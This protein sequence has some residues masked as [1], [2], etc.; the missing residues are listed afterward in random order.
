MRRCR[1]TNLLP[2]ATVKSATPSPASVTVSAGLLQIWHPQDP[3]GFECT[4]SRWNMNITPTHVRQPMAWLSP[5]CLSLLP[6]NVIH[7]NATLPSFIWSSLTITCV[8]TGLSTHLMGD[9]S[10]VGLTQALLFE[11]GTR[12]PA[13]SLASFQHYQYVRW[14]SHL[15]PGDR[16]IALWHRFGNTIRLFDIYT[17]HLCASILGRAIHMAILRDGTYCAPNLGLRIWD[18]AALMDED[19]HSAHGYELRL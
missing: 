1:R 19:W 6:S 8:L 12:R 16:L 2:L 9:C 5:S 3:A 10:H 4:Y 14:P 11:S 17:G 7:G 13:N 18:I 15:P